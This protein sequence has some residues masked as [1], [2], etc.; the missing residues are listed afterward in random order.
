MSE[1]RTPLNTMFL[2]DV[3]IHLIQKIPEGDRAPPT[4]PL[5]ELNSPKAPVT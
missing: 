5:I 4:Q 3:L 1:S 2:D